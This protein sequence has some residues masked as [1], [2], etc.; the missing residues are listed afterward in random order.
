[1]RR[2]LIV[3]NVNRMISKPIL[4]TDP[5]VW[6]PNVPRRLVQ[7]ANRANR[8]LIV[9]S[10]EQRHFGMITRLIG[11]YL[12]NDL[13]SLMALSGNFLFL[14]L[15]ISCAIAWERGD[16]KNRK[17]CHIGITS[18]VS[19]LCLCPFLFVSVLNNL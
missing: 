17:I 6:D 2:P 5:K 18:M 19:C 4:I 15:I 3:P 9:S 8:D 12:I 11:G 13:T 16:L 7:D 10:S 1:M 14:T